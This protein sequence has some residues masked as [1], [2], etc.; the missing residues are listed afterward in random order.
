MDNDKPLVL[1]VD[2][3]P[4]M[5]DFIQDSLA[6]DC[7][8]VTC[9]N[10]NAA[11]DKAR[12]LLPALIITDVLM[13]GMDGYALCKAIHDDF[14]IG[15]TPVLFLS[16][17]DDL[18]NRLQ[19]FEVGGE[20]F[21]LKPVNP[22]VLQAKV[23]HV[24]KLVDER[25]QLKNQA[26]YATST[27]MV[28]MTS[29]SETGLLIEGMKLFNHS[30]SP[31]ALARAILQAIGM[32]DLE[33]V[34]EVLLPQ[35]TIALNRQG[36]ASELEI[37]VIR[38]MAEMERITQYRNRL[39]ICYPNV[40][41]VIHNLPLYDPD[42]CG[43][44]RDHL[45]MLIEAAEVRLSAIEAAITAQQR[46]NVINHSV[47]SMTTALENIDQLQRQGRATSA[48][49]FN[50]VLHR[51]EMSLV[52]LELSEKQEFALLSIIREGFEEIASVQLAEAHFQ[53]LLTNMVQELKQAS[54]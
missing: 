4:F 42:R 50:E 30:H 52:G 1:V 18:E 47:Q 35:G 20:D 44:L 19:G 28:A 29:M 23:R 43:R 22:K 5:L 12:S 41:T 3:D 6:E 10:A 51:V 2:D 32:F 21:I 39:S 24:L 17:L 7:R 26:Q 46:G 54:S 37:S 40:R 11:L 13:P 14:D 15:D 9:E 38:H 25:R 48:E 31:E 45:A 34:V 33:C 8:V 49:I 16:A 53:D 27:A 36:P